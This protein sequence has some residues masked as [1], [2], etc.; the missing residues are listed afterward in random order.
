MKAVVGHFVVGFGKAVKPY[1]VVSCS[2]IMQELAW[3]VVL[4]FKTKTTNLKQATVVG[5]VNLKQVKF[6]ENVPNPLERK[7]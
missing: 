5:W 6:R 4:K 1:I 7:K 2:I 3:E